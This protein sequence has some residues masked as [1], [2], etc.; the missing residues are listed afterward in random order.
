[1]KSLR[2]VFAFFLAFVLLGCATTRIDWNS[3]I[4]QY[5]YDD[6]VTELGVPDRQAQLS[7]G[8]IVGEWLLRRGGAY[9]HT[10]SFPGS[11]FHTYDINEMP[12]RYMRLVFGPDMLLRSANRFAR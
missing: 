2:S 12:D 4:G 1:M 5:T 9:G 3:R 11:R 7:D 8:S 10:H 6:A